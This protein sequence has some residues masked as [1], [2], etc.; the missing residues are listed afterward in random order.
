M[1]AFQ[2]DLALMRTNTEVYNGTGNPLTELAKDLEACAQRAIDTPEIRDQID[3][4]MTKI[5]IKKFM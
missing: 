3:Q 4:A 1:Q 2:E 5:V